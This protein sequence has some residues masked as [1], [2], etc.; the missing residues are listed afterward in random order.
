MAALHVSIAAR[1]DVGIARWLSLGADSD[2]S[3]LRMQSAV[4]KEREFLVLELVGA[5]SNPPLYSLRRDGSD[6]CVTCVGNGSAELI[7]APRR[8]P[9]P[10][11]QLFTLEPTAEGRHILR[12]AVDGAQIA[13]TSDGNGLTRRNGK[14]FV[15]DV[16][17]GSVLGAT[18]VTAALRALDGADVSL[19]NAT[20]QRWLTLR[21]PSLIRREV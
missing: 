18:S 11:E 17:V 19:W 6:C 3:A 16:V 12:A 5:R 7:V 2:E 8:L 21:A 9:A 13:P 15:F 20:S 4:I 1:D 10:R 14:P